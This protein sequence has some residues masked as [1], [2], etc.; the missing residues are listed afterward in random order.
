[1]HRGKFVAVDGNH[2]AAIDN[3][4]LLLELQALCRHV[5]VELE[6]ERRLESVEECRD[7]DVVVAADGT[8]STIRDFFPNFSTRRYSTSR[9]TLPGTASSIR[10]W[11]T[12]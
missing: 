7:C 11:S 3:F 4:V 6:F 1:M 2:Y 12:R 8:N 10:I 9:T 5:G